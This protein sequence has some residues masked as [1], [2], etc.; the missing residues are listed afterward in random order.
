VRSLEEAVSE[1]DRELQVRMR[2][3]DKWIQE[4][5]IS[6]IDAIDRKER[7]AAAKVYLQKQLDLQSVPVAE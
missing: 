4:G 3:Y 1:V 7:L 5:K 2:I 6:R